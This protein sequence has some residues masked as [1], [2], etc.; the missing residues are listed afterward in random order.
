MRKRPVRPAE[1][2]V[3]GEAPVPAFRP[4]VSSP[5]PSE[6]ALEVKYPLLSHKQL[7]KRRARVHR[8]PPPVQ[9]CCVLT[10]PFALWTAFPPS[11]VG[12]YSQPRLLRV[13][14]HVPTATTDGAPAPSKARRAPP[15]RFPR[16][17]ST[18]RQGRRS[19]VPRGHR[20]ALPQHGTRPRPPE[21]TNGWPRRSPART[22][23]ERPNSPQ[24]PVSGLVSSIGASDTDSSPTPFCL[25]STP[26]PLAADRGSI[27]RGCSRPPSHLRHQAAPQLLP[28][29]TAAE[30]GSFHPARSYG[31]SWRSIEIEE[32]R[33]SANSRRR[34]TSFRDQAAVRRSPA[35]AARGATRKQP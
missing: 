7:G 16:S 5:P 20:H 31:A 25:V 34:H 1:R 11:V 10:G 3:G 26:G 8:R 33:H 24:P 22:R 4:V 9:S 18:D 23:T 13:L 27:V 14:R 29:V 2:R 32:S 28:T 15:G 30:G 21:T 19:A 6:P 12:R 17:P 35:F